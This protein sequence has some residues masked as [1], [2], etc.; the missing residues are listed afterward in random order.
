[1]NVN[2]IVGEYHIL[3]NN[4]DKD[5]TEYSGTL[6]LSLDY[7]LK[8]IA[9]WNINE[10]QEQFGTGFFKD[11][12]LVINFSYK[13]END[14]TYKGTVVYKFLNKDIIDGFWSEKHG[15]QEFLGTELGSRINNMKRNLII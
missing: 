8:I 6:K 5:A 12:I 14:E 10:S 1:M 3:G 9:K 13:G 15:N 4:Q 7:H 2:D 11:N